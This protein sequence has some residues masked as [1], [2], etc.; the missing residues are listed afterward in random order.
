MNTFTVITGA[1]G[2]VGSYLAKNLPAGFKPLLLLHHGDTG[3][4]KDLDGQDGVILAGCD[5]R[6]LEA[7]RDVLNN[8]TFRLGVPPGRLV[9]TAAIR[10]YDAKSLA[11][12]DPRIFEEVFGTNV[13]MAYNILRAALPAMLAN[14]FGRVVM[15]GSNVV[16][17]GLKHGSAYAAAKS[18]IV[19]LVRSTALETAADN[20]LINAI[21]PAPVDTVLEEDYQGEYLAFRQK[22]FEEYRRVSST[23]KLVS[24]DELKLVCEL[25]LSEGLENCTG[26]NLIIDGGLSH[27]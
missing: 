12:S 14:H 8:A 7:L 1:N 23:G 4:I 22:Y 17:T 9:H 11:E 19:S 27:A 10:S 21:S 18:A 20:V 6:D 15:F 25:L 5:M 2:Q 16:Q 13:R 26:C 24:K 3:R